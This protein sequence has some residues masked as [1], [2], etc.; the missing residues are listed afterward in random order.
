L[1]ELLV[2]VAIIALLVAI[3]MPSLS[4]SKK[5]AKVVTCATNMRGSIAMLHLYGNDHGEWPTNE[6]LVGTESEGSHYYRYLTRQGTA[7]TWIYQIEGKSDAY[8]SG[9]YRCS[10]SLP[11]HNNL[12]GNIPRDGRTWCW[13]S[14]TGDGGGGRDPSS[15]RQ[16]DFEAGRLRNS[17]R[18]WFVFLGPLRIY[19]ALPGPGEG[20]ASG[21]DEVNG[22]NAWDLWGDSWANSNAINPNAPVGREVMKD[23]GTNTPNFFRKPLRNAVLL[24]CPTMMR[25]ENHPIWWNE[26]RSPHGNKPLTGREKA[27]TVNN[28]PADARNY[29]FADGRVQYVHYGSDGRA[30]GL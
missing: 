5:L 18:S 9:A 6:R 30:M 28:V 1:I 23:R 26:W 14:R 4:Q 27:V 11:D 19:P 25:T 13:S 20:Y 29:G 7:T 24:T 8:Y 21:N 16:L 10:E 12:R 15:G 3:L 2:V 17:E 22:N